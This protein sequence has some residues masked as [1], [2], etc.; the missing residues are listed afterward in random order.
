MQAGDDGVTYPTI[1]SSTVT[2]PATDTN[3]VPVAGGQSASDNAALRLAASPPRPHGRLASAPAAPPVVTATIPATN[4]VP[5]TNTAFAISTVPTTS[6][7]VAT[8]TGV[9]TSTVSA[10]ATAVATNAISA[11]STA[12]AVTTGT[13]ATTT[14]ARAPTRV[15]GYGGAGESSCL[16]WTSGARLGR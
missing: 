4:T 15:A 10:T 16:A 3:P 6:T 2:I 1:V 14:M 5:A 11:M 13:T 12:S 7:V 9:A 8:D